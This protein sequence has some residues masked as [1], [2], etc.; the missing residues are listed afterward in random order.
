[1]HKSH[2]HTAE[3]AALLLPVRRP[4][5]SPG[6]SRAPSWTCRRRPPARAGG[7]GRNQERRQTDPADGSGSPA[8]PAASSAV[9]SA[10]APPPG[11]LGLPAAP[12]QTPGRAA[13]SARPGESGPPQPGTRPPSGRTPPAGRGPARAP[14]RRPRTPRGDLAR[15][16]HRPTRPRPEPTRILP[17]GFP[18]PRGEAAAG[19]RG[20]GRPPGRASR[21]QPR[22]PDWR[23]DGLRSHPTVRQLR[24]HSAPPAARPHPSGRARGQHGSGSPPGSPSHVDRAGRRCAARPLRGGRAGGGRPADARWGR[25]HD[26]PGTADEVRQPDRHRTHRP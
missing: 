22:P 17:S 26:R 14:A 19:P 3:P 16:G 9:A 4:R 11:P 21:P 25:E 8:P 24:P 23:L 10:S 15:R 7:V 2:Q 6:G 1:M 12:A 20:R 13:Q 18:A 5:R